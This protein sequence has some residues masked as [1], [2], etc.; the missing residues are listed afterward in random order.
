M[1][2]LLAEFA[3]IAHNS[4]NFASP[5]FMGFP[6]CGNSLPAVAA[7]LLVPLLNQNLIN[8]DFCAPA[9]TFIEMETVH[10]L[11]GLVGYRTPSQYN[12]AL[13]IGGC[14]VSG[15]VLANTIALL[16]AREALYPGSLQ[17]GLPPVSKLGRVLV[18][19]GVN[20]YSVRVALAWLGMGEQSVIEVPVDA[21]Y[22][23]NLEALEDA[24][25]LLHARGER[26][27]A[28]VAYAGD[29]RTMAIDRLDQLAALLAAHRIWFHVDSC[30]GVQLLFSSQ[31]RA[32]LT[33]LSFADSVAVDPHKVLCIPYACS[34]ILFKH[35]HTLAAIATSSDL[36]TKERWALGQI[37][38]F[39]GS[40]PF[41]SLK[42]WS[43]I[44]C[45]G[46]ATIG[47]MI[48]QRLQLHQEIQRMVSQSPELLLLN[49]T[50]I[51]SVMFMYV[52]LELRSQE[53]TDEKLQFVNELN[54]EIK[55]S[56]VRAGQRHVH[57]F[58]IRTAGHR[59]PLPA[60]VLIQPLRIMSGNPLLTVEH[61]RALLQDVVSIGASLSSARVNSIAQ[62]DRIRRTPLMC[63]LSEWLAD[64]IGATPHICIVYG[65][66]V[67]SREYFRS[68][69]DLMVIAA[70]R[71]CTPENV[72]RLTE[73]IIDLHR[74]YHLPLDDEVPFEK[75]L[76]VSHTFADLSLD[77][78]GLMRRG[79]AV[80][81]PPIVKDPTFLASQE[82]LARLVLNVLSTRSILLSGVFETYHGLRIRAIRFV[83]WL[84]LKRLES[85]SSLDEIVDALYSSGGVS[86]EEFL[87]YKRSPEFDRYF[88][89]SVKSVCQ[90]MLRC[91]E[92]ICF[93]EVI[94]LG[95]QFDM[96][97][98]HAMKVAQ[99]SSLLRGE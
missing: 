19:A 1:D 24:I 16:A 64:F 76:L 34:Y 28:C 56:V 15:G 30:H 46:A 6:D 17:A 11:R 44:K 37:T 88:R 89:P 42:L 10:W 12:N 73:T 61:L 99:S 3:A 93:D 18:P 81:I 65:S 96:K 86:G 51:N 47:S 84:I 98:L 26:A 36:I 8:Q 75:K 95:Q 87:G 50:D 79:R 94:L 80:V 41:N 38:P 45:A 77:G 57:S 69:I 23:Y 62:V 27:L 60:N 68:D 49:D 35:P 29:S 52:P 70:D 31:H 74:K 54:L 14:S 32:A 5:N 59:P 66:S 48:E 39:I 9:A 71:F 55:N 43:L 53:V 83:V 33:G 67:F 78:L 97:M 7:S 20:H 4:T 21:D 40:K 72:S 58:P 2:G 82:M 13:E 22:R 92:L 85:C 25:G 91:G 63:E 90:E